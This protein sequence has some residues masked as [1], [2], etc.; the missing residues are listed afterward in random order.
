MSKHGAT[1]AVEPRAATQEGSLDHIIN[2]TALH[3]HTCSIYSV[4]VSVCVAVG[5]LLSVFQCVFVLYVSGTVHLPVNL[6][7][8]TA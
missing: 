5:S 2:H 4:C 7:T 1:A 3:N 8:D 6:S